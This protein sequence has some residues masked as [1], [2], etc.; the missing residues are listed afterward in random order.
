MGFSHSGRHQGRVLNIF[1]LPNV[2]P[3]QNWTVYD[4][5]INTMEYEK[6]TIYIGSWDGRTGK[7]WFADVKM[8]PAGFT[9]L[10]RR[11]G[12]PLQATSLDGK[13]I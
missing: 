12:A 3:T 4:K 7:I 6:I 9:N 13:T 5:I 2:Q 1:E 8:E 10:V 11:P